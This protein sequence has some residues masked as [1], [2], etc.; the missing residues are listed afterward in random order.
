MLLHQA[1]DWVL[2]DISARNNEKEI[3]D[4]LDNYLKNKK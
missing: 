4:Y 1:F 2:T 3:Y